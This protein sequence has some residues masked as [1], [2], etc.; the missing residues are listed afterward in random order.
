MAAPETMAFNAA[1]LLEFWGDK[2]AAEINGTSCREYVEFRANGGSGRKVKP[3]TARRELDTL[4]AALNYA[5]KEGRLKALIPVTKPPAAAPR[6][7]WLTRTEVAELLLGAL[8]FVKDEDGRFRR[9]TQ[10]QYHVAR[11][12]LVAVYTGTRH[13]AALTLRWGV[14][15]EGGWVDLPNRK[16]Y[17]L[18]QGQLQTNKRRPP[19]PI[20]PRLLPHLKRWRRLTING[21][22]EY[23]GKILPKQR[24]GFNNAAD[25]AGLGEITPHVFK[26]TAITWMMQNGVDP[27]DVSGFTGTSLNTIIRVY[28]H[29]S[30][31]YLNSA[32]DGISWAK[33]GQLSKEGV[34][35]VS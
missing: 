34:R 7:R 5:H 22:C 33:R 29:H 35:N 26:H 1:R 24:R 3:A 14:N 20:P 16:I 15:S 17:R 11:F 31:D 23:F 30:P 2:N 18:P 9:K 6:D 19:A 8:G 28:G 13:H 27:W 32:A 12:I 21:P 4:Q 10:P 25:R